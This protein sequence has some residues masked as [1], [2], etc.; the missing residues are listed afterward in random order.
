M[1][2]NIDTPTY[3]RMCLIADYYDTTPAWLARRWVENRLMLEEELITLRHRPGG[4]GSQGG[5]GSPHPPPDSPHDRAADA[6][7]PVA[8]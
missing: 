1:D 2:L 8:S 5:E 6:D 3:R 4:A 7:G